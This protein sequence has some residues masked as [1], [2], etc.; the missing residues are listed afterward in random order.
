M[1]KTLITSP[2]KLAKQVHHTMRVG[3]IHPPYILGPLH[4]EYQSGRQY[5]L[6]KDF[7]CLSAIVGKITVPAGYITDFHS[8]P[9][10]FWPVLPPDD[11]AEGAVA[12]DYL[13]DNER[14]DD[15][16]QH[17][18]PE[19]VVTWQQAADVHREITLHVGAPAWRADLMY[20]AIMSFGPHWEKESLHA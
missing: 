2:Q 15:E 13:C 7:V 10:L 16:A 14:E 1:K 19:I 17:S 5:K 12:H 9:R 11:W 8:I 4:A 3:E 18:T 20:A 6:M